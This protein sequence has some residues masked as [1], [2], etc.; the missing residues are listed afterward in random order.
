M[1]ERSE[2]E[3]A[4]RLYFEAIN[5][6]DTLRIPLSPDVV[7]DGPMMPEPVSGEAAVR[8]YIG[9]TAPF[10]ARI[11][12][13]RTV[14]EDDTAGVIVEFEGLNGVTIQ[15]AYF[16]TIRDGLITG[17]QTF[18]DTHALIKGAS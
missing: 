8:R 1:S 16:F 5:D 10:I 15:G 11:D 6:N 18:F 2:I 12:T 13:K 9:E 3:Q 4:V 7:I 17:N 14:I